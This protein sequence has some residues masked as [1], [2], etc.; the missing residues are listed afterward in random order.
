LQENND[1]EIQ[2]LRND[3]LEL[4]EQVKLLVRTELKLRRTQAELLESKEQIEE[5]SK[6]L[7]LRVEERTKKLIESEAELLR[8]NKE[9]EQFAYIASH[10]LQEPLRIVSSYILLMIKEGIEGKSLGYLKRMQNA[11][12]RMQELIKGLLDFSK[13]STAGQLF[14]T[15][16]LKQIIRDVIIDLEAT[17]RDE[18]GSVEI[19]KLPVIKADALQM[20]QL[21]QNF[22]G[23]SLKF[24]KH[25]VPPVVNVYLLDDDHSG[26]NRI[27]V[28][29]NGIGIDIK[30]HGRIFNAFQRLHGRSA[31][32]GSGIGL[33]VCKK[34][35]ERHNG[36]ID[37]ESELNS[38][39]RFIITLPSGK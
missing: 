39:T 26:F 38:G 15:V 17:I 12:K 6:T 37:I 4:E 16:N 2:K 8:S 10:D 9:L 30:D 27:V 35:V 18:G 24:H 19:G 1:A 25:G 3:C 29:D 22:I 21:F 28:E 31:F 20:R 33:A 32:E 7:E 13:I 23:N 14:K 34:I 11:I 36:R 5:Y